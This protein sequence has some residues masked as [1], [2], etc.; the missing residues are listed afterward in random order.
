MFPVMFQVEG[1]IISK[2]LSNNLQG[3]GFQR[4]PC[5]HRQT[6]L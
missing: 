2:F 6:K 5:G 3:Q 4:D 1:P